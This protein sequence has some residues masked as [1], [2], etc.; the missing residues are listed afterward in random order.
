MSV[1]T[2]IHVLTGFLGSGKTTLLRHLLSDPAVR[3]TAVIVNEFGE[4]GLD[5]LLMREITDDVVLL[6]SGCLC[7][8]L[9][10]DLI[11][12]ILDL[13]RAMRIGEVPLF[14]RI[15]VE[16]TGLAD[17]M[18]IL[19]AIL[20]D[21][22]LARLCRLGQVLT[23]IDG[24][25]GLTT[26]QQHD[27]AVRQVAVANCLI[28]TKID[29]I[30]ARQS[31]AVAYA[32]KRLNRT[33]RIYLSR[34]EAFPAANALFDDASDPM[35]QLIEVSVPDGLDRQSHSHERIKTFAV[36]LDRP[37]DLSAFIEWLELL[38]TSRGDSVLRVKGY[39]TAKGHAQPLVIQGVQH[40]VYRPVPLQAFPAAPGAS[41]LV[42]ITQNLSSTAIESSLKSFLSVSIE[43][44]MG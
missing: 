36:R 41:E 11:S 43:G 17:P 4:I 9:R 23:T 5:H 18:P 44:A 19:Q 13:H 25:N 16:T 10:G 37:V 21:R 29:L 35:K 14:S 39:I 6:R 3:D 27:E 8:A 34:P 1:R 38:L 32:V 20:N 12:S 24:V 40:T 30:D 42:F 33:A 22:Q 7:C 2:P 26:I 15:A 31:D 28:L